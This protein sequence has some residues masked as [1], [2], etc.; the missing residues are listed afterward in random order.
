M[1]SIH[2]ENDTILYEN[3]YQGII[4]IRNIIDHIV[5]YFVGP[6]YYTKKN[7]NSN[8]NL[9]NDNLV[10]NDNLDDNNDDLDDNNDNL[11]DNNEYDSMFEPNNNIILE[12][13]E[14]L[15]T[16]EYLE[17][18]NTQLANNINEEIIISNLN[19]SFDSSSSEAVVSREAV[20]ISEAVAVVSSGSEAV[21]V[22]SSKNIIP[23]EKIISLSYS[24]M[25]KI[26][27]VKLSKYFKPELI[28]PMIKQFANTDM[29]FLCIK[30]AE[31]D[32]NFS[33]S[34]KIHEDISE[35][36]ITSDI[37][38]FINLLKIG[39]HNDKISKYLWKGKKNNNV[40]TYLIPAKSC[41]P[42]NKD[43]N[44]DI[45]ISEINK[46]I[47]GNDN[48]IYKNNDNFYRKKQ[49][50]KID[51]KQDTKIDKN[52]YVMGL[53]YGSEQV[54]RN[55]IK[56]IKYQYN[57]HYSEANKN[58]LPINGY[59]TVN[60]DTLSMWLN[61]LGSN[62]SLLPNERKILLN[63][64]NSYRHSVNSNIL[65]HENFMCPEDKKC[66]DKKCVLCHNTYFQKSFTFYIFK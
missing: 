22:V 30:Y 6:G 41:K 31:G 39:I 46:I 5:S 16:S 60:M 4:S 54:I 40:K 13:N 3:N 59:F 28:I 2:Q 56:K 45:D 17:P 7:N 34:G 35:E 64:I 38:M 57:C 42:L 27:N 20:V 66:L 33:I 44:N 52:Q 29:H 19:N 9:N 26:N 23:K 25:I 12:L 63:K 48:V 18:Q 8:E 32:S 43:E 65:I 62:N 49:S 55:L 53:I 21:V 15:E 51:K 11:E 47:T 1:A 10:A 36:Y 58:Y 61:C 50:T 37:K 24:H 14:L